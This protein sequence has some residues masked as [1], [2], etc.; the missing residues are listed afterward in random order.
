M[1]EN[2]SLLEL[3][4]KHKIDINHSCEGMGSCGTCRVLIDEGL[5][6]LPPRNEIEQEMADDRGFEPR[7]RL[8]CQL[9]TLSGFSFTIPG[10]DN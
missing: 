10:D 9:E 1:N 8:A 2:D 3:C 7:E 5:D 6:G 4:I